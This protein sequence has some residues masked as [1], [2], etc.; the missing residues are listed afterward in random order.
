MPETSFPSP[1]SRDT[2]AGIF[3][4]CGKCGT[5]MIR[6]GEEFVRTEVQFIPAKLRVIDYY[7]ENYECRACRKQGTLYMEKASIPYLPTLHSFASASTVA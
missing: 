3:S 2:E 7:R 6:V 1:D 4:I 5:A